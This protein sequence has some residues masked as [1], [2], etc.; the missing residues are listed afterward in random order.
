[1]IK[2]VQNSPVGDLHLYATDEGLCGLY[3]STHRSSLP[4]ADSG[5]NS[6]LEHAATQ[7]LEYFDGIRTQ[8][9]L[10][11][12]PTGTD[13]QKRVWQML[14]TIPFGSTWTYT[15]LATKLGDPKL[16]RAV[17]TANGANPISI[18]VPCHRVIASSGHLTGYAGGIEIKR[19]LLDHE[20][21][22]S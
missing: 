2:Q 4:S 19:W 17:G 6:H 5:T 18:I 15:E 7:L 8:F 14:S 21:F 16:T 13:F 10:V 9:E 20:T 11:L 3:T 12:A 22:G 1:M